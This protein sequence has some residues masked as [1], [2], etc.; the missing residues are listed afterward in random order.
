MR[1]H[2]TAYAVIAFAMIALPITALQGR[3]ANAQLV[4][5]A[6]QETAALSDRQTVQGSLDAIGPREAAVR[7]KVAALGIED[8]SAPMTVI[9]GR[10]DVF[11]DDLSKTD[12]VGIASSTC[13][14]AVTPAI[15]PALDGVTCKVTLTGR[16]SQILDAT[17][18]ISAYAPVIVE[19]SKLEVSRN[20][21][22]DSSAHPL[23]A[24][25]LSVTLERVSRL[26]ATSAEA[27]PQASVTP[28]APPS[29]TPTPGASK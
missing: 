23:L 12:G 4:A 13:D 7:S 11:L 6:K 27:S 21:P 5:I 29:A 20:D 18:R 25:T 10:F 24:G 26:A 16:Y 3:K 15:H 9:Q 28:S 8:A 1:L 22:S 19:T 14:E 2:P 17:Q